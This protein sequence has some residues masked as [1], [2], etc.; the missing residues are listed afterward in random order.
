MAKVEPLRVRILGI[1]L[2]ENPEEPVAFVTGFRH[3]MVAEFNLA[4]SLDI[5]SLRKVS[6]NYRLLWD[7]ALWAR[8]QGSRWLDLGG[9]TDCSS[10]DSLRGISEFKRRLSDLDRQ[11][12]CEMISVMHPIR[13]ALFEAAL[14]LR[15]R[16]RNVFK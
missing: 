2:R 16:I 7:L 8:E 5:D 3:G 13:Y 11:T 14:G 10:D 9:V 15:A 6:F 12:G 1:F 4:G